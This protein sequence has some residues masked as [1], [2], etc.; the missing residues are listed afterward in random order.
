M[1]G[2]PKRR[3]TVKIRRIR[4]TEKA[5]LGMAPEIYLFLEKGDYRSPN[6]YK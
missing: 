1:K 4:D 3:Y 6:S 5:K 2:K